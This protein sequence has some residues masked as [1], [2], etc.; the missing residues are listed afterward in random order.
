M[1]Y[2]ETGW[3]QSVGLPSHT[4][5]VWGVT[6]NRSLGAWV[7]NHNVLDKRV[8]EDRALRERGLES[9]QRRLD[10]VPDRV[11]DRHMQYVAVE[12]VVE[13]VAADGAGCSS[14]PASGGAS[15]PTL[16]LCAE[17]VI[18]AP[19]AEPLESA[20]MEAARRPDRKI[21]MVLI[22]LF[23]P[24]QTAR[25][26]L[27]ASSLCGKHDSQPADVFTGCGQLQEKRRPAERR[28]RL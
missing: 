28:G 25:E 16:A 4:F 19:D 27:S 12:V 8:G 1:D 3:A 26:G 11:A 6:R 5:T 9:E 20:M 22:S 17:K 10:L 14:Q 21:V 7:H 15:Q 18:F 23:V 13:G 2:S 24:G